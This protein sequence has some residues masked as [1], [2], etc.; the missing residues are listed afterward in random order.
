M[1]CAISDVTRHRLDEVQQWILCAETMLSGGHALMSSL[2]LA[3][4]TEPFCDMQEMC[5]VY[6]YSN[7][8]SDT[9][10]RMEHHIDK[11]YA[12]WPFSIRKK[13]LLWSCHECECLQLSYKR[14][15]LHAF[16][17]HTLL[18]RSPSFI[19]FFPHFCVSAPEENKV[20]SVK[21]IFSV[22]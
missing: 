20:P 1:Y 4:S 5:C 16:I 6:L 3:S 18:L 15:F 14:S 8:I 10:V 7:N 17:V 11:L 22:V 19:N 9:D 21:Q 13:Y 2:V 12:P